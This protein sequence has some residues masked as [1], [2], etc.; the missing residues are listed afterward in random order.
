MSYYI[1][2]YYLKI[3]E[4]ILT[5]LWIRWAWIKEKENQYEI[6]WKYSGNI[7]SKKTATVWARCL[8]SAGF[9]ILQDKQRT[10]H[11]W[12]RGGDHYWWA[13]WE[14][15]STLLPA[16]QVI[17]SFKKWVWNINCKNEE[18]TQNSVIYARQFTDNFFSATNAK[19]KS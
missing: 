17:Q 2:F 18:P 10:H 12:A 9:H 11:E 5:L 16:F 3:F 14:I 13:W 4:C 6:L 8:I 7:L 19:V 1:N 15:K